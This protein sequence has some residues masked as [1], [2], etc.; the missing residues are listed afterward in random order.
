MRSLLQGRLRNTHL[1][2]TKAM[3]PLYEAV[4]NSIH[5]IEE[6]AERFGR[7]ITDYEVEVEIARESTLWSSDGRS[8]DD[9]I[10][11]FSIKDNGAGF[12]DENWSS[13]NTLDTLHKVNKGSRG[14]GRLMW[15]KAF[16]DVEVDSVFLASDGIFMRRRFG[17]DPHTDVTAHGEPEE[18]KDQRQTVVKL[19]GFIKP[20]LDY[21]PKTAQSISNGILEHCLWY[22][23]RAEG[24][25]KISVIDGDVVVDLFDLYDQHMH[26][27]ARAEEVYI[28]DY[29]FEITHVKFRANV[30]KPNSLNYCAAGRLVKTEPL[31]NYIQSITKTLVDA[32]GGY[33]YSAYLTSPYLNDRVVEQRVGFLIEDENGGLFDGSELSFRDIRN[34]VIPRIKEFLEESLRQNIEDSAERIED[35]VTTRAPRYRSILRHIDAEELVIDPSI[36]DRDLDILLHRQLYKVE[37]KILEDGHNILVP[38]NG[39]TEGDYRSRVEQYL[40]KVSDLKQSDLAN[41]VTHRKVILELLEAAIYKDSNGNFSREDVLH[42]LIV[43][44][45]KTSDDYEFRRENLWLIDERLTFHDFLASD[46]PLSSMMITADSSGKEPDVA[47]IRIFDTPFLVSEKKDP[48]AS[49][50]IIEI[51]RPMRNNYIAGKDEKSDPI[52]Q[53]LD[54][55]ARLR[56]G[57][58][59]RRG[60]KIPNAD[61]IPGF[62]YI[63][64]DLTD[65]MIECCHLFNLTRTYDGL[66]YFGYHPNEAYNA[67]IQVISFDGLLQGAKER[68]RAFFDRLGLP[69][70]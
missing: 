11:G 47:S 68:N 48:P 62:I 6:D 66:G 44:M 13:F 12:N 34:A 28:G 2:A 56:R 65:K 26:A 60:R 59:T 67:Y 57:A 21:A 1:P 45:Q 54:Y 38:F 42:D 50:T 23:V 7:P 24:V 41:Y 39:E 63:V 53:S 27:S 20:Y 4:V 69:A 40:Q 46:L 30:S 15:L 25:P 52:R 32:Q 22:F 70:R 19:N 5:A 18:T 17:F 58:A 55:L 33:T 36:S 3:M 43:P 14:I 29:S 9:R 49:L 8:S 64:A 37:E 16:R 51:K 10:I 35:F 31:K 61:R